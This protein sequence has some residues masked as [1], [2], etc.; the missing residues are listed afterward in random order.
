MAMRPNDAVPWITVAIPHYKQRRHL[1]VVLETLFVQDCHSFE[2]VISDDSSPDDSTLVIPELLQTSDRPFRYY[3]QPGNLGYDGNVRFCLA[4]ALGRYVLLLGNDDALAGP[5]VIRRITDALATLGNPEVAFVNFCDYASGAVVA[6]A[7]TTKVLGAGPLTALRFFRS[8][9]FV[10]GLIYIREAA[11]QHETDRWDQSIYYQIYLAS[12]IIASGGTLASV[13][14]TAVRKDVR[15]NDEH[16]FNYAVKWAKAPWSFQSRHTGMDSVIRVTAN[17][18][19]PLV[20]AGEGTL[21]TI[22]DAIASANSVVRCSISKR[23]IWGGTPAR[24]I[25]HR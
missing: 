10:A 7:Q 5:D 12:R 8:F 17:A 14:I 18:I 4:A 11:R 13:A 6:R 21:T 22:S 24:Y 9:S 1:Q 3:T 20:P 15:V 25:H 19:L 2:I 23:E 16:V